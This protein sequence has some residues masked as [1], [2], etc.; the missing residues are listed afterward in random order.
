M[1]NRAIAPP[2]GTIKSVTLIEPQV[3]HL[4]NGI[5]IFSID[6]GPQEV[7]RIELVFEAGTATADR[8]LIASATAKLLTAGTTTRTAA[9][10]AE[11]VDFYGAYLQEEI[12]HDD[13]SIN[14]FTLSKHLHHTLPVLAD[15]YAN[16]TFLE[17]EV[18]AYLSKSQQEMMVKQEK[19]SY[20]GTKAFA[21]AMFGGDHPY[22]R[23]AS[24]SDYDSIT[25]DEL[26][27]FYQDHIKNRIKH[28]IVAG[29]L[30]KNTVEQ[31]NNAF[32]NDKR[33]AYESSIVEVG[34]HNS[35]K[36][37]V[38]KDGAVQNSIKI[39][40]LLFNR[41][42]ADFNGMRILTTVLGGYFGSRLMSNIREDKGY[43]YGISA[44]LVSM[45]NTGYLSISTEVGADV[46]KPAIT[47][48]FKEIE[49]LRKDL[50][51]TDELEL[52]RN[53]MLGSIL[54]SVDGPFAIADKWKTY[55]R[56]DLGV[57]S[58]H[59][60]IKQIQNITPERLRE[61]ANTYMK[62]NDLTVVTAG[63]SVSG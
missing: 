33:K 52:V 8:M 30:N 36:I 25:R 44:G 56:Y 3:H 45:K 58:H 57:N 43:T 35:G 22:G 12:A 10:I 17:E 1:L 31:L 20:L 21:A 39:G 37:H 24:V 6:A 41:K 51:S 49:L 50:V 62:R 46:C 38:E 42:H 48:I 11:S 63:K 55:L 14:L 40:R 61:L 23:S 5:P 13:C 26:V 29:N 18:A 4:D 27:G 15:V 7:T 16:P 59:N 47:E 53:Y 54:K 19:V 32:G 60:L 9:E 34:A 2:F 28:I